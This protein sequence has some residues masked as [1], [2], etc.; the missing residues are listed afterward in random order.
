MK[1]HISTISINIVQDMTNLPVVHDSYVFEKAKCGLGPL[2]WLGLCQTCISVLDFFGEIDKAVS[3][4]VTQLVQTFF[5]CFLCVGNSENKNLTSS[6][7]E[8]FLWHWKLGINMYWVQELMHKRYGAR[9]G[10]PKTLKK[11]HL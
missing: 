2:M 8:L 10:G 3:T 7:R 1:L 11:L 4:I 6:Q 5:P 9:V